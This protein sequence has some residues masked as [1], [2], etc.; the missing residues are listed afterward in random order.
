MSSSIQTS[1]IGYPRIGP[2]REMKKALETY[3]AGE[4]PGPTSCQFQVSSRIRSSGR[5]SLPA[6]QVDLVALVA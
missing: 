6:S 5:D 4:Y 2:N 1:T 3:W